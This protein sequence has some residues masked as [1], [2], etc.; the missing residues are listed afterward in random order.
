[1]PA[2]AVVLKVATVAVTRPNMN[3]AMR[4]KVR[5]LRDMIR[6]PDGTHGGFVWEYA[7]LRVYRTSCSKLVVK[8]PDSMGDSFG[9]Q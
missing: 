3:R 1:M 5:D 7:T 2:S 4:L 8:S 9:D 6:S